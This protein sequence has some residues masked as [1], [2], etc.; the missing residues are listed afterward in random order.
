M[1][2]ITIKDITINGDVITGTSA[3]DAIVSGKSLGKGATLVNISNTTPYNV[4]FQGG[5]KITFTSSTANDTLVGGVGNSTIKAGSGDNTLYVGVGSTS[6]KEKNTIT[7]GNGSNTVVVDGASSNKITVGSGA[8]NITI[9]AKGVDSVTLGTGSNE[10]IAENGAVVTI[11]AVNNSSDIL[12]VSSGATL[13]ATISSN[14]VATAASFNNGGTANLTTK[15]FSVNLA[16]ASGATGWNVTDTGSHALTFTGGA[17]NDTF[18]AGKGMD[19]IVNQG[20]GTDTIYKFGGSDVLTIGSGSTANVAVS[21]T[22]T[23]SAS[24]VNNGSVDL[25]AAKNIIVDVSHAGGT[26]GFTLDG[27]AGGDKLTG[28]A[29]AD[30]FWGGK[31]DTLTLGSASDKVYLIDGLSGITANTLDNVVNY[32]SGDQFYFVDSTASHG[33]INLTVGGSDSSVTI[34]SKTG[35]A[36]FNGT[37]PTSLSAALKEVAAAFHSGNNDAAGDFAVFNLTVKHTAYEYLYISHGGETAP[38][39]HDTLVQLTGVS[40]ATVVANHISFT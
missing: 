30:L 31:G 9:D 25:M 40:S 2:T 23:A 15:G 5:G 28:G 24:T 1:A 19:T 13:N 10:V 3:S 8:N 12:G 33:A 11:A 27:T 36:T 7:A 21:K 22:W 4:D 20:G 17:Q 34:D 14:W 16:N 38:S 29:N 39:T 37:Q 26:A 18:T 6:V 35:F 32:K